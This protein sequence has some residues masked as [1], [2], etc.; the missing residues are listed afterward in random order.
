MSEFLPIFI[1]IKGKK[2]V[3]IGGGAVAERKIKTLLKYGAQITVISPDITDYI[4]KKVSTG[5]IKYIKR[6][7]I[8][9][10]VEDAI[11]VVAATSDKQTNIKIA[12][13]SS[14]LINSVETS[15]LRNISGIVYTVPAI[16]RKGDLT[17]AVSTDFPALSRV[18][19]NEISKLYGKEFA[20]YL[21]Y[22]KQIRKKI[23]G[24]ISDSK[25]RQAIFRNIASEKI[26]SILRQYGFKEA[27]KEIEKI[28]DEV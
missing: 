20:S 25:K 12:K 8:K 5:K 3:V 9:K 23:Q 14:F 16:V 6:K 18:I 24:Q 19:K 13:D 27:K 15:K 1:N 7:Y 22:L 28:I 11:L 26:V 17:I 21:K 4:Q 10:D 2:C